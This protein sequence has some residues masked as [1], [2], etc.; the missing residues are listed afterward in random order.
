[1]W[2]QPETTPLDQSLIDPTQ[3]VSTQEANREHIPGP[4]VAVTTNGSQRLREKA[5]ASDAGLK[6]GLTPDRKCFVTA[7]NALL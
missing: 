1:M 4:D 6:S 5:T 7:D 3:V 2:A